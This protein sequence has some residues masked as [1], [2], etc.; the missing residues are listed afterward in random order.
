MFATGNPATISLLLTLSGIKLSWT[1]L[2]EEDD[3]DASYRRALEIL[4]NAGFVDLKMELLVQV[5]NQLGTIR[6][7]YQC[8]GPCLDMLDAEAHRHARQNAN[9]LADAETFRGPLLITKRPLEVRLSAW[10][11]D[12]FRLDRERD[13]LEAIPLIAAKL[14]EQTKDNR[15]LYCEPEIAQLSIST[16]ARSG[17]DPDKPVL[18][19]Q[20]EAHKLTKK[21]W[22]LLCA[23][24]PHDTIDIE[25]VEDAVWP[26]KDAS[27]ATVR[28]QL[29]R[30]ND[31]MSELKLPLA[32]RIEAGQI[33]R[34]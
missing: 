16:T 26:N 23:I 8:R 21:S 9:W 28:A 34:E 27:H 24:W 17:P 13:R 22:Q 6:A 10:S 2:T 4:V 14:A 19:W 33:C 11:I 31:E 15:F 3:A 29:H 12:Q 30:L 25:T 32:W 7:T 20:G 18:Y 1:P 5:E